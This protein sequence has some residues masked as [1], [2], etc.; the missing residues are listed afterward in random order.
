[1][2]VL[3]EQDSALLA[4][5]IPAYEELYVQTAQAKKTALQAQSL[6]YHLLRV[7]R[8]LGRDRSLSRLLEGSILAGTLP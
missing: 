8:P 7:S 1:M 5:L 2:R 4:R 6:D 3:I